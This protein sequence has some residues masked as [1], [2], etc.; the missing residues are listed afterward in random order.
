M[1]NTVSVC[2]FLCTSYYL[3]LLVVYFVFRILH[4][5]FFIFFYPIHTVAI[6]F[7]RYFHGNFH[8]RNFLLFRRLGDGLF[9]PCNLILNTMNINLSFNI[10]EHRSIEILN[11]FS[12]VINSIFNSSRD[13]LTLLDNSVA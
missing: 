3:L 11:F 13:A 12:L 8:S 10:V 6:D 1:Y 2:P 7:S 5:G 9:H 4:K